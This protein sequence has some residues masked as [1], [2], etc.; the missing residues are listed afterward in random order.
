MQWIKASIICLL[1]GAF[2]LVTSGV[3]AQSNSPY[4]RYGIGELSNTQN[5]VNRA[6]GGVS[7]GYADPQVVNFVNPASYSNLML[8]TFDVG[9]EAGYK[10]LSNGVD[11]YR[12]GFGTL[13]YIQL[14]IPLRKKWGMNVGLRPFSDVSYNISSTEERTMFDTLNTTVLNQYE[15]SGGIYQ[16]YIGTGF[17]IGNL[18]IGANLG[19][20]FGNIN[21]STKTILPPAGGVYPSMHSVKRVYNSFYYNLGLQYAFKVSKDV[22]V[23]I[24]A[25]G[26]F[27]Q[28]LKTKQSS[29]IESLY[30]DATSQDYGTLDTISY[31]RN[32]QANTIFPTQLG[33]G[34]MVTKTDKYSFGVD[35]NMGKWSDFRNYDKID[36]VSDA[37]KLSVGGQITPNATAVSGSY[38]NKVTYRL[39]AFVGKDYIHLNGE[40][41]PIFGVSAGVGLPIR[42]FSNYTSQFTAINIGFEGGRRGNNNS[43]LKESYFR[44]IIGFTLSDIWFRKN[45]YR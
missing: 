13:S 41:L 1:S 35:Y 42:R 12:S 2:L 45:T 5:A 29:M 16:A 36:S 19:Y 9:V 25:T 20:L 7:Q 26:S 39:G 23:T 40:N 6:M 34:I 33:A 18:S 24:G 3:S 10:S 44:A 14:G 15:G 22:K 8:T 37:W 17:G 4:S 28:E 38:W 27:Q 11:N 30:Y 31:T 32:A 21:N 43:P